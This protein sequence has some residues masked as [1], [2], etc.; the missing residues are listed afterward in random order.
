[1]S[2]SKVRAT[3]FSC[4]G[5]RVTTVD[6]KGRGNGAAKSARGNA[7]SINKNR[8]IL[9][10]VFCRSEIVVSLEITSPATTLQQLAR[11]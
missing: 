7:S 11:K 6:S 3:T 10:M 5:T 9:L 4:S 1:M 2:A 8:K